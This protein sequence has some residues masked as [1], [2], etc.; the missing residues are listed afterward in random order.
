MNNDDCSYPVSWVVSTASPHVPSISRTDSRGTAFVSTSTTTTA[1][2]AMTPLVV[3]ATE[4]FELGPLD[5]H[6]Q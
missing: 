3:E 6:F 1:S 2:Y 5:V 4:H